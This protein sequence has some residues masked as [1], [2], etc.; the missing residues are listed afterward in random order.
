MA[1]INPENIGDYKHSEAPVEEEQ[2][3]TET[4]SV[5]E[6]EVQDEQPNE[7]NV[8]G[9]QED[10]VS[11]E[12]WDI[13]RYQD[14]NGMVAGKFKDIDGLVKSYEHAEEKLKE[15][16]AEKQSNTAKGKNA[17]KQAAREAEIQRIENE[18]VNKYM[19][20]GQMTPELAAEIKEAGGDPV[21]TELNA[22]KTQQYIGKMHDIV[23][24]KETFNTMVNEMAEGKTEAEKNAWLRTISDPSMS[25]YAVKG[26]YHEWM[27]K[28]GRREVPQRLRGQA[29][30][31]GSIKPYSSQAEMLADV[32]KARH[33]PKVRAELEARK[34][35]TPDSVIFNTNR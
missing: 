27:Q 24:G 32:S 9:N 7:E 17:E 20:A 5:E 13:S 29:S 30:N 18:A 33:D 15:L 4:P 25:E 22:I 3:E 16:M 19:E 23:G 6:S 14:E 11:Q 26:L 8:E 2:V 10:E 12:P 21:R 31:Q 34:R 1:A 28:T 35:I